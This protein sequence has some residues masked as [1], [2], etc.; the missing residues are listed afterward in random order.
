MN[1]E[2]AEGERKTAGDGKG[3]NFL[4][5]IVVPALVLLVALLSLPIF[6]G[7]P[8][9]GTFDPRRTP[10]TPVPE[11]RYGADSE[12]R[13]Q[14]IV[15]DST[16]LDPLTNPEASFWL[17]LDFAGNFLF[18]AAGASFEIFYVA[19][20]RFPQLRA[21]ALAVDEVPGWPVDADRLAIRSVSV[22]NAR[23]VATAAGP[24]GVI[25]W[26]TLDKAH[27]KVHYRDGG[28]A[29]SA[30]RTVEQVQV[31]QIGDRDVV[32][33]AGPNGVA[34]YDLNAAAALEGCLED[35]LAS[36]IACPGVYLGTLPATLGARAVHAA[37]GFAVVAVNRGVTLIDVRDPESLSIPL[38]ADL[39]DTVE[40]A[41]LWLNDDARL[42]MAALS[43]TNLRI[44]D[45]S[46][47]RNGE[48]CTLP[49]PTHIRSVPAGQGQQ[50]FL[51]F[52]RESSDSRASRFLY[53]GNDENG[54]TCNAQREY[55]LDVTLPDAPREVTPQVSDEGYWGWYY[56]ACFRGAGGPGFNNVQPRRGRFRNGYFYRTAF[57]ILDS[58][59]YEAPLTARFTFR[60]QAPF[61]GRKVQFVDQS[62]GD[63]KFW[64]WDFPGGSDFDSDVRDP[65]QVFNQFGVQTIRLTVS[66][67]AGGSSTF[68]RSLTVTNPPSV[69]QADFGFNPEIPYTL[70]TVSFGDQSSG[71]PADTWIWRFEDG[72]P[73]AVSGTL[74]T[75]QRPRVLFLE[76]GLKRVQLWVSNS[77]GTS[78]V[79]KFVEVI[80]RE[81]LVQSITVEPNPI[82]QCGTATLTATAT[83]QPNLL[84]SWT[85]PSGGPTPGMTNP[86]LWPVGNIAPGTY[87]S[88]LTVTN[89]A[90]MLQVT[91]PGIQ[92]QAI[93]PIEFLN[94][95]SEPLVSSIQ[96]GNLRVKIDTENATEWNWS[97]GD[98]TESGWLND[99]VLG[100]NPR[101]FYDTPGTYTVYVQA[102]NCAAS[103]V[104]SEPIEVEIAPYEALAANQFQ[105]ACWLGLC[106]FE[107][108]QTV[109]FFHDI[110][111]FPTNFEYDWNGDNT[112]E[113]ISPEPIFF[114][115]F[116]QAGTFRPRLRVTRG[117]ETQTLIDQN[118]MPI[119]IVPASTTPGDE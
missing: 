43:A 104:F 39:P 38:V 4:A 78:Y 29:G 23:L 106:L 83:G 67:P 42:Y 75:H 8:R 70:S 82:A 18:A 61:R 85:D 28:S 46:C 109:T 5:R 50:R 35:T 111:G 36:E 68:E 65:I 13:P 30:G 76:P 88:D 56:E 119:F 116:T 52:S 114:H 51:T 33:A 26:D 19:D 115:V 81:P 20:P 80:D 44:Y 108:G 91:S 110:E 105:A 58:H 101:H 2:L 15:A 17:D 113:E 86:Y 92:V 96:G 34:V 24:Q 95:N 90:G 62:T 57:S 93:A 55:L 94:I 118:T 37:E 79:E 10:A 49:G 103:P 54:D 12:L 64:S 53:V 48:G 63:P 69:P 89:A 97:W 45:V 21:K 73:S 112:F 87:T 117:A 14:R 25:I 3:R 9:A 60:P 59:R 77:D 40:Q 99:P 11:S 31:A 1:G 6:A 74:L 47:I 84:Y 41:V 107:V 7:L 22:V 102:R 98:G 27:P 16:A 100:L 71:L 72:A 66:S 32:F